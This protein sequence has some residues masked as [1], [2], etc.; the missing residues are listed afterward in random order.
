MSTTEQPSAG[1][2]VGRARV[3]PDQL[4]QVPT[5]LLG[6]LALLAVVASAPIRRAPEWWQFDGTA[7]ALRQGLA[8]EQSAPAELVS[9]AETLLGQVHKFGNRAAEV[10]FLAGSAYYRQALATAPS[11]AGDLWARAAQHLDEAM[12]LGPDDAD[13]PALQYRLGRA[14]YARGKDVPRALDLMNRAVEKGADDPLA[15]YQLLVHAYLHLPVPDLDEA[16]K[17]S[18]KVIDL[19][20]DRQIDALA[21]A[22]LNLAELLLRKEQ[23]ALAIQELDRIG[24]RISL[25][26][27]VKAR[28][29]QADCCEKEGLW[30]QALAVWQKL[31]ADAEAVPGGKARVLYGV[32]W[33]SA[34]LDSPDV[35]RAAQA[36]QDALALG[37]PEG[38]AAGLRLGAMRLFGRSPEPARALEDWGNALA[39]LARPADYRNPYLT[40]AEVRAL[41]DQALALFEDLHDFE[42]MQAVAELY[43]KLAP[44]GQADEK[45]AEAAE[46]QAKKLRADA[47]RPTEEVRSQFKRAGDAYELAAKSRSGKEGFDALWH[48]AR[49]FL[50]AGDTDRAADVLLQLNRLSAEDERLAEG[51]FLLAEAQR[52]AGRKEKAR[53]AYL[54]SMEYA[55]TPFAARSR[56]QLAMDEVERKN[57]KAAEE[58]LQ[59]N[60]VGAAVDREAH[61]KSLYQMA[62]L[63]LQKEDFGRAL[64]YLKQA[65]AHYANNPKAILVPAQLADAYRRLADQAYLKEQE[66]RQSYRAEL[67]DDK[68]Q[69][70]EELVR[71][72]QETRRNWLRAAGKAYLDLAD[73][74]RERQRQRP[75]TDLEDVLARRS[76][77][78]V[79]ECHHDLGEFLEALRVYQGV[80]KSR[81]GKIEGL[82]ACER[83]VQLKELAR[84]ADI[85]TPEAQR[86]VIAAAFQAVPQALADL[87]SM[88]RK[89]P[90]F[91]G[92]G[93][94][95]WQRWHEWLTA[96]RQRLGTP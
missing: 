69:Q 23:R 90:D 19:T 45:I 37:G 51:W 84:R 68:R 40:L 12:Q 82:I 62:W 53:P 27:R 78:G 6:L 58:I 61:E 17:A 52:V 83:I 59:P 28:L 72:H 31:V 36:W 13:L 10:Y 29:L 8:N 91:E 47:Q 64:L 86:E 57:W 88:D 46:A 4:W 87:E 92:A 24:S 85:L 15:G 34:Q 96:E 48:G 2:R 32:G 76:Q 35:A 79:A 3:A 65:T 26:L 5:F 67:P 42:K 80:M 25:P 56:Y 1:T 38:Q 20:D 75:L 63:Q 77:L 70:I 33:C 54:R 81:R 74:L 7:A 39:A 21:Q 30:P 43:R 93:V 44:P 73:E 89:A 16:I 55:A 94:W 50:D 60:L 95:S 41:F 11:A 22:R 9:R 18:R 49:C 71:H 66:A 14:L